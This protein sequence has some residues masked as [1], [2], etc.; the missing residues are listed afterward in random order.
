MRKLSPGGVPYLDWG[1]QGPLL[2]LAHANGFPP[3]TY[4]SFVQCL[5]DEFHVLGMECRA[6]WGTHNPAR[7][8]H[9]REL[10]EDLASFL[11]ELSPDGAL[12]AGHSL[13]AVTTLFCAQAYPGLIRAMILIDP[14]ILPAWFA[15]L[16]AAAKVM[17]L[18][19][20]SPLAQQARQRRMDWPSRKVLERACRLAAP[21]RRWQE[22]FLHDYIDSATVDLDGGGVRLRY[23]RE[24]EAR[25]FETA[26][27][28]IWCALPRLRHL[29]LLVLR[30]QY[31]DTY[32]KETAW[33]LRR[34]W[35]QAEFLEIAG[36]DH[37]VPMI[38]PEE[39]A[40]AIKAFLGAG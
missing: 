21:F 7:L 6:L 5:A 30:G 4:T 37:F 34:L 16:W 22:P 1:G 32:R 27:P 13:G 11:M 14:V 24:W 9:W 23:P 40:Q 19:R 17:Q 29:P 10:G 25:I 15:P 12:A 33:L 31:S 18:N 38:R 28:D 35:P 8:R 3:G 39:T 2:H 36:A 20:R 26:P